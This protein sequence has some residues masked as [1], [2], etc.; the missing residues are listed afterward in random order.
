M[1]RPAA[2]LVSLAF[3]AVAFTP[4]GTAEAAGMDRTMPSVAV[5]VPENLSGKPAPLKVLRE[6]LIKGISSIGITVLDDAS[7]E[8]FM[9]RHRIRYTGGL[10]EVSASAL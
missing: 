5:F 7:L 9:L 8:R 3:L 1:I 6:S 10:D 4:F 2:L